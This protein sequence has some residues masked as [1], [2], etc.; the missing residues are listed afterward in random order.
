MTSRFDLV[1]G[2][3]NWSLKCHVSL[4]PWLLTRDG[5]YFAQLLVL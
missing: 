3:A 5:D 2:A 1:V 4:R